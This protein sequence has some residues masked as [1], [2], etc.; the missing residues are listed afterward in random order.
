[1]DDLEGFFWQYY[2]KDGNKKPF[3]LASPDAVKGI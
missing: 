1:M 2:D 3:Q